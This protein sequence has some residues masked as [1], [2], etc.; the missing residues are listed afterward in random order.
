MVTVDTPNSP[1]LYLETQPPTFATTD[2]II[3]SPL[4]EGLQIWMIVLIAVSGAMASGILYLLCFHAQ[5]K[6]V[7]PPPHLSPTT[8]DNN[9][10]SH[11]IHNHTSISITVTESSPPHKGDGQPSNTPS[12]TS[13]TTNNNDNN[14]M[15]SI[16][17]STNTLATLDPTPP[18]TP[19]RNNISPELG[20]SKSIHSHN[21]LP[22]FAHETNLGNNNPNSKQ[23]G[24]EKEEERASRPTGVLRPSSSQR[25][26]PKS[27]S[28]SIGYHVDQ[29]GRIVPISFLSDRDSR[30]HVFEDASEVYSRRWSSSSSSSSS[31]P[32]SRK[33]NSALRGDQGNL[34][35]QGHDTH[36]DD[37]GN[38]T[39]NDNEQEAVTLSPG[40]VMSRP[41]VHP[42]TVVCQLSSDGRS[43][44]EQ[45]VDD[46]SYYSGVYYGEDDCDHYNDNN[47]HANHESHD[48]SSHHFQEDMIDPDIPVY[49][50]V[51]YGSDGDDGVPPH[52]ARS[53]AHIRSPPVVDY[54]AG[55]HIG[56]NA[57]TSSISTISKEQ[58]HDCGEEWSVDS[59]RSRASSLMSAEEREWQRRLRDD[60]LHPVKEDAAIVDTTVVNLSG[61]TTA[62]ATTGRGD[63]KRGNRRRKER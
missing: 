29:T 30:L 35:R 63:T 44:P 52:K 53:G 54:F 51:Y 4:A 50:G 62:P 27:S 10:D 21:D 28:R 46:S 14:N 13:V 41:P 49:G 11:T 34:Q 26:I 45:M 23:T 8:P 1:T 20:R 58:G 33:K 15:K 17:V 24:E 25:T 59:R 2:G 19:I 38:S 3:P 42:T 36:H 22:S 7:S 60:L 47:G 55:I 12:A 56:Q 18:T 48:V 57:S 37:V 61:F 16:V 6:P 39:N 9:R 43:S 32:I 5:S 40:V 31:F